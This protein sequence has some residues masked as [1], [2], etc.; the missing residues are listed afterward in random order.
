M[1]QV[2]I[3]DE[4]EHSLSVRPP[5][6]AD[7]LIGAATVVDVPAVVYQHW[8]R[9]TRAFELIQQEMAAAREGT[10]QHR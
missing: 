8:A 1:M 9:I 5:S 4:W 10:P 7:A 3:E 2:V 6:P